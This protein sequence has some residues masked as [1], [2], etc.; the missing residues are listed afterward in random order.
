V[1]ETTARFSAGGGFIPELRD[2]APRACRQADLCS[3]PGRPLAARPAESPRAPRAVQR[4]EE[5]EVLLG[6]QVLRE[7][8]PRRHEARD[9]RASRGSTATSRPA[10]RRCRRRAVGGGGKLEEGGLAL[11][12]TAEETNSSPDSMSRSRSREDGN[13]TEGVR[14]ARLA[15]RMA[16]RAPP[17]SSRRVRPPGR[18][19]KAAESSIR[20]PPVA[21]G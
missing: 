13:V 7:R 20:M 21:R 2:R 18:R 15:E 14:S 16:T 3:H 17:Q 12:W 4:G 9:R 6:A 5:M 1:N 11:P 8:D 10:M 19:A